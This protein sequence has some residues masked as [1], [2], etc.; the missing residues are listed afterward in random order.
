[1]W[2]PGFIILDDLL[3]DIYSNI[4][5]AV[6][7]PPYPKIPASNVYYMIDLMELPL[8]CCP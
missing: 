8:Y 5:P 6:A 1:M 7:I 2:A 4:V 3:C